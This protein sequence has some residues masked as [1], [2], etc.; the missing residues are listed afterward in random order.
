MALTGLE[1][2]A[3]REDPTLRE[4]AECPL[5]LSVRR[6]ALDAMANRAGQEQ[7]EVVPRSTASPVHVELTRT[8]QLLSELCREQRIRFHFPVNI[9]DSFCRAAF[10]KVNL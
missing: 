9:S 1:S 3:R 6:T 4:P 8:S 7:W 10:P 5:L 2:M